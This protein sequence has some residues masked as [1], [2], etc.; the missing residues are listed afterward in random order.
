MPHFNCSQ[1][2]VSAVSGVVGAVVELFARDVSGVLRAVVGTVLFDCC[3]KWVSRACV[4]DPLMAALVLVAAAVTAVVEVDRLRAA[5]VV[6][7][8]STASVLPPASVPFVARHGGV[9]DSSTT[10]DHTT[11]GDCMASGQRPLRCC[12]PLFL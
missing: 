10:T 4:A 12:G 3:C 11:E 9:H 2:F 8:M 1:L 5:V 7:L 6:P